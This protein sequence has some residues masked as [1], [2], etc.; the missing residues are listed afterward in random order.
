MFLLPGLGREFD[1]SETCSFLNI[2]FSTS[3]CAAGAA[4]NINTTRLDTPPR[5][6][7]DPESQRVQGEKHTL[8]ERC[9]V[10]PVE[11]QQIQDEDLL[12]INLRRQKP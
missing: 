4:A 8:E 11:R 3:Y 5:P 1:F 2:F 9:R 10:E 7:P 6:G 12:D